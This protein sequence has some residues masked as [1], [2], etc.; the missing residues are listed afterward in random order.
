MS[1]ANLVRLAFIEEAT[2]GVT[3]VSGDFDTARF[4]SEGLSGTPDTVESQQIRTDRLSSGQIVTG[5]QVGGEVAFELAK[6]TQLEKFIES[7]MYSTWGTQSLV[8]VGLTYTASTKRLLRA[9]GSW[10]PSIV[11][12]DFIRLSGFTNTVNNVTV[13]VAEIIDADEIRI[14]PQGVMVDET[15]AGA[16]YKRHDKI[17]IGTT[18]KSFSME[19]AFLD[20]T[21]K[22]IIY[23][24]MIASQMSLNTAFG[25][26]ITGSFTFSGNDYVTADAA[27]E[28]ITDG[29]TINAPATTQTFNGSIDMPFLSNS[30]VGTLDA[31]VLDIQSV[32]ISLNNNLNAQNVIGDVAPKDY[33]AGTAAIEISMSAYLTDPAWPILAKKLTQDPFALGYLLKNSGGEYGFYMPAIQVSFE[34]PSSQGINQ[35]VLLDMSGQAKVGANGESSLTIYR[36]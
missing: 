5:L 7:A 17:S 35:D 14:I 9:S 12:G 1:S 15:A 24:G 20:L 30:A 19:K 33:S 25:E 36:L 27:N 16:A 34:D 13:M 26:L 29:R 2:Y 18:K 4:T 3:P 6:E 23:R 21:T 22:A 11:V 32:S 10:S 28:F 8:T 31:S